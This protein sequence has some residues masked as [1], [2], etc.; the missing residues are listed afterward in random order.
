[1]LWEYVE[2]FETWLSDYPEYVTLIT[3]SYIA[4]YAAIFTLLST[5]A[6]RI[7]LAIGGIGL[8]V[9]SGISLWLS[10]NGKKRIK[11]YERENQDLKDQVDELA[12]EDEYHQ[13]TIREIAKFL[14]KYIGDCILKFCDQPHYTDRISLYVFDEEGFF[15]IARYSAN[16]LYNSVRRHF[17][18]PDQGA[19]SH[20][21]TDGEY[22]KIYPDPI[23]QTDEY[24]RVLENLEHIP[25]SEAEQFSMKPTLI[26]GFRI[27]E[28]HHPKAVFIIESTKK[29]RFTKTGLV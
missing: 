6:L 7:L 2:K 13:D 24:Y 4:I 25:R 12:S 19:I 17:Y 1:M 15:P 28:N 26:Y 14:N 3:G 16:P 18:P 21:W 20:T 29:S 10:H 27:G 5:D 22:F 9:V 11:D 23:T 8:I